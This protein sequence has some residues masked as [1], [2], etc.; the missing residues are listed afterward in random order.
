MFPYEKWL[1]A[2]RF[3]HPPMAKKI[4]TGLN[5]QTAAVPGETWR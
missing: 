4:E 5:L 1:K 2:S 3:E